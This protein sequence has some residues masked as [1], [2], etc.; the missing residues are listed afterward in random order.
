MK[1][2]NWSATKKPKPNKQNTHTHTPQTKQKK[3]LKKKK[4]H[5]TPN[6]QRSGGNSISEK[7]DLEFRLC[8]TVC[9][10][11]TYFYQGKCGAVEVDVAVN[12]SL[13][14]VS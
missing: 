9:L 4:H 12:N 11:Q 1:N 3:N 5:Q 2:S 8:S 10:L 6:H 14:C 13:Q 7:T